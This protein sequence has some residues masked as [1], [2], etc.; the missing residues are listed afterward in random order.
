MLESAV[1]KIPQCW[2]LHLKSYLESQK[3]NLLRQFLHQEKQQNKIVYPHEDCIFRAFELTHFE[4]VKVVL[5][6]Q[7]PYHQPG[8][9]E[10]LSFSVANKT[11]LLLL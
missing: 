4:D 9:A 7:D 1:E 2:Y 10:G 6:G 5:L 8:Q 3:F 11:P